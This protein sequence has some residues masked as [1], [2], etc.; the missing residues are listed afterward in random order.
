MK[1][2]KKMKNQYEIL[3]NKQQKE[4]DA[5]PIGAAFNKRQFEE[6]MEKWGLL[7]TDTDKILSIGNGAFIRKTDKDAFL[8]LLRKKKTEM[9]EAIASDTTGDG[10]ICDMFLY[11][12]A[13]HEY[14]ITLNLE[15]TLDA[16]GLTTEEINE[17]E[18]LLH[19]L[20]K[21][22]GIYTKNIDQI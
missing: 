20:H 21:A 18:R 5:F 10:F 12:L 11:E 22:V 19:G 1:G 6:M 16:L 13:N 17:D 3:K 15:D 4:F 8:A 2:F 7:P 9:E 14:C